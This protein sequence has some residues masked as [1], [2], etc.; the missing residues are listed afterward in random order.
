MTPRY[1]RALFVNAML[2]L[3]SRF[4]YVLLLYIAFSVLAF[5]HHL[6]FYP[7]CFASALATDEL[8]MLLKLHLVRKK[9]E[10]K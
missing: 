3:L 7:A 6:C 10:H 9:V 4:P 2:V 8:H 5:L 1:Q